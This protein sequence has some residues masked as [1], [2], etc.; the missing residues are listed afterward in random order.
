MIIMKS[1]HTKGNYIIIEKRKANAFFFRYYYFDFGYKKPS[2][3]ISAKKVD[4]LQ[5]GSTK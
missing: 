4:I 1:L 3:I 5:F 2:Y